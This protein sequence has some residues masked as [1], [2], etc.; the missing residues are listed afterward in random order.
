[1]KGLLALDLRMK[2][3]STK[4]KQGGVGGFVGSMLE[5]IFFGKPSSGFGS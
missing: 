3:L 5:K 2:A 4:P 1:M